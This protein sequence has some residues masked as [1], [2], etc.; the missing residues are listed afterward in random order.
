MTSVN[1]DM[2]GNQRTHSEL[3]RE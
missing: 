3:P 1:S 2:I